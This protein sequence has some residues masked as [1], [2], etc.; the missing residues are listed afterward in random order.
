MSYA[1]ILCVGLFLLLF[2]SEG[3]SG[4]ETVSPKQGDKQE[5]QNGN[6]K[7]QVAGEKEP[8]TQTAGDSESEKTP[9]NEKE[10]IPKH[11]LYLDSAKTIKVDLKEKTL[12]IQAKAEIISSLIELA[13]CYTDAPSNRAH[14]TSFVTKARPSLIHAGLN[15]IGLKEGKA[16]EFEGQSKL[17]TGDGVYIFVVWKDPETK[18]EV[19]YR[20]EQLIYNNLTEE[21]LDDILWIFGGGNIIQLKNGK[22][23]YEADEE[24]T[25]ISTWHHPAAVIDIPLPEGSDDTVFYSY[26]K[27]M[28][29]KGQK[30]RFI[31]SPKDITKKLQPEKKNAVKPE[32][33]KKPEKQ[34]EKPEGSDS[35]PAKKDGN[36]GK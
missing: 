28:P 13:L 16:V 30:V 22:K 35:V 33:G 21:P 7:K 15:L 32:D 18:K 8:V 25:I 5:K 14:E 6:K 29:A 19:V 9:R 17:P 2:A 34:A 12:E 26:K 20:L 3:F 23:L 11:I 1:R 4:N 27:R 10:P 36:S 24:G 31:F